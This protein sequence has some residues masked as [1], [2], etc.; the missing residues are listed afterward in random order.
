MAKIHQL[1]GSRKS[2]SFDEM[3]E[4]FWQA[5]P[6]P[7]KKLWVKRA[8]GKALHEDT[9]ENIMVGLSKYKTCER[10]LNGYILDPQNWLS[11]GSWMDE[12][13]P[14]KPE[15]YEW[16]TADQYREKLRKWADDI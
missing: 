16:E 15:K 14:P 7:S 11:S 6:R 3:L 5:Y 4:I 13:S 10:V 8:L 9:F 12:P 2:L 1:D